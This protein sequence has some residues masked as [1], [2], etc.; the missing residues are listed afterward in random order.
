MNEQISHYD[1][2]IYNEPYIVKD[3]C[4][5]E[6]VT[7]K[8]QLVDVKLADFVPVLK[9]EVTHDDGVEQRKLFKIA[10]TY[11]NG[12]VLQRTVSSSEAAAGTP[13]RCALTAER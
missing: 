2:T 3:G 5:Y 12:L 8:D 4:L 6:Q 13:R 9:A 11:K 10:A 7:V 1:E